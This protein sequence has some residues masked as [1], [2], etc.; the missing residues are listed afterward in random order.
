MVKNSSL[1]DIAVDHGLTLA[2]SQCVMARDAE[3]ERQMRLE[4]AKDGT[5]AAAAAHFRAVYE[6]KRKQAF[7][8]CCICAGCRAFRDARGIPQPEPICPR[9]VVRLSRSALLID[10]VCGECGW[11]HGAKV[12]G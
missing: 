6:R 4:I 9:C 1:A 8:G 11:T 7:E 12:F 2:Q 3:L 10:G 5:T